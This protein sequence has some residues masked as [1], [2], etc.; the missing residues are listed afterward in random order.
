A[1]VCGENE[2]SYRE[3]EERA[4]RLAAVLQSH[5]VGPDVLV[6]VALPRSTDLVVALLAVLKAGG[7]YLPIDP[8]YPAARVDLLL[9]TADPALVVS[10]HATAAAL[11]TDTRHLLHLEDLHLEEPAAQTRDAGARPDHLAYVMFTSGSTGTPKG[12]CVTHAAVVN[13][14]QDL[15]RRTHVTAGSR[16]LAATS[17]NFDVSVFEI[18]TALTCGASVEIVRDVLELAERGSWS[19]STISAVPTVFSA[20]LDQI[21]ADA[22]TAPRLDVETVIFA[23]EALSADL[24]RTVRRVLPGTRVINAYGQTESFY[25]STF[26]VPEQ[27]G[28][29]GAVPVGTPLANMRAAY[30]VPPAHV[31]VHPAR[32]RRVLRR[33]AGPRA[34]G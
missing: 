24:V 1:V 21:A 22:A 33:R 13:G 6:A 10:D 26:T 8:G 5:G 23:G 31:L 17:V 29:L 11:A 25:T 34:V 20:L 32:T 7:A 27:D 16:M 12:V 30:D 4:G 18:F 14:V 3:L 2:L 19:G 15:A 28:D 9:T